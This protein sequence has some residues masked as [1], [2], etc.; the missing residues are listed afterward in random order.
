MRLKSLFASLLL[1]SAV[2]IAIQGAQLP[3]PA[4]LVLNKEDSSLAIVDPSTKKVVARVPTGE[5]PHEVVA[6]ADG[7]LAFVT[8]YG[9]RSP[10]STLSII[11]LTTQK[12]V[13]RL[14]LGSLRRPHGIFFADDRVY[15]T[16]EAN[17]VIARYDPSA[18]QI[19]WIFGT[20]QAGT[21]IVLVSKDRNR[22]FTANI[23]GDSITV[24][25]RASESAPWNAIVVP[26]GKGPEGI[27]LS[28]D[29]KELWAAHSRDG[30]VSVIDIA[31]KKVTQTMDVRTKRSNRLKFTPDGKR[32]L[33]SD[34]EG[35]ELVVLDAVARTESKRI[36]L[37]RMPEG[38]LVVPDGS[39]A[40]VAVA[41]ENK[42]AVLD[43]KTFEVVDQIS[44]G[45]GPDGMAWIA[46]K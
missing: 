13:R 40:Y 32:V 36:Q 25:E 9:S 11:D 46:Q 27:D 41:G 23:G 1:G 39:R 21:H 6:S 14:D 35:G 4:L 7:R 8:N 12:E 22:I 15:F 18:N 45:G 43:L 3:S 26:V 28:P 5:G 33:I 42:L 34:L 19:D 16:A 38:I 44:P 17:R 24:I 30:G 10:G 2:A 20:G 31:S 37:G 29:E